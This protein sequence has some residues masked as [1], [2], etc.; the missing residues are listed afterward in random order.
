MIALSSLLEELSKKP[1]LCRAL[2]D[3]RLLGHFGLIPRVDFGSPLESPN[4]G[5]SIKLC[6]TFCHTSFP[7]SIRDEGGVLL[8]SF[9]A[10]SESLYIRQSVEQEKEKDRL[11]A[12]LMRGMLP[13]GDR[14]LL[15]SFTWEELE[16]MIS[17]YLI[18]IHPPTPFGFLLLEIILDFLFMFQATSL[19][20]E[21]FSL[22]QGA[23]PA[24]QE[25]AQRRKLEDK[26]ERLNADIAKLKEEKKEAAGAINK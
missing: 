15:A 18:K 17:T 6:T 21:F 14:H 1:Y 20:Q 9:H 25:D 12:E 13:L 26:M 23:P 19:C 3:E 8:K 10:S 11:V 24:S 22:L 16:R 7:P 2:I 5:P 4:R